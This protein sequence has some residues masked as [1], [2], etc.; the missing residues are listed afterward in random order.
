MAPSTVGAEKWLV[1]NEYK[2]VDRLY[3]IGNF[4]DNRSEIVWL[5]HERQDKKKI[6]VKK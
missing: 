6:N 5:E 3:S 2:F 1:F 4:H